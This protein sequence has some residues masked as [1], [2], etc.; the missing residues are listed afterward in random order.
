MV[1]SVTC[2]ASIS[3]AFAQF[4]FLREPGI[5]EMHQP[6]C[7]IPKPGEHLLGQSFLQQAQPEGGPF[8]RFGIVGIG[9]ALKVMIVRPSA[10]V[11]P[12]AQ[13]C[14]EPSLAAYAVTV[15]SSPLSSSV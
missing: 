2:A 11:R 9:I 12:P 5:R 1:N 3:N 6:A 13:A 10:R 4:T 14:F 7:S 15:T 8:Q